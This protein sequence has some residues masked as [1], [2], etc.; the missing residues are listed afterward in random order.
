MVE[1]AKPQQ[2]QWLNQAVRVPC[3]F[4]YGGTFDPVHRGHVHVVD[5]LSQLVP[6]AVVH[7]VIAYQPVHKRCTDFKTRLAMLQLALQDKNA[8][9]DLIETTFQGPSVTQV[10]L[11]KLRALYPQTPLIWVMGD[12]VL[13]SLTQWQNWQALT[14]WTHLYVVQRH[15]NR[16][17]GECLTWLQTHQTQQWKQCLQKKHG[18]IYHD[19]QLDQ[20]SCSSTQ[21]RKALAQGFDCSAC[22]DARVLK[23]ILDE[24]LY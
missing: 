14:Q 8:E 4:F 19:N 13:N 9:I 6:G 3:R 7:V 5:Y 21:I 16:P 11:Q 24:K 23:Y 2:S 18:L 22:L 10:T 12:D 17:S 15:G 1:K 20:V